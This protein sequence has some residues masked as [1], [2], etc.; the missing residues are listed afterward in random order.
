[1]TGF[2]AL[3]PVAFRRC[4]NPFKSLRSRVV[5]PVATPPIPHHPAPS[6]IIPPDQTI[7]RGSGSFRQDAISPQ[8]VGGGDSDRSGSSTLIAPRF[9]LR[10]KE[11]FERESE[12]E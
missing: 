9:F 4:S 7:C 8:I 12:V 5:G 2:C 11:R 1:M 3:V 6:R 10:P